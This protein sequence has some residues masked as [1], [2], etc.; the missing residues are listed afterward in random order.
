MK[1]NRNVDLENIAF[2]TMDKYGFNPVYPKQVIQEVNSIKGEITPA[3]VPGAKDLRKLMW[4]SIDNYDSM[5]LDQIEYCEEGDNGEIHVKVA[6]ADVD[7]FVSKNSEIDRYAA[8]NGT[9]V[10]TGVKTFPMLPD[11]LSGGISSLLPDDFHAAVVVEYTVFPDG[12]IKYGELYRALVANSAKLVYEEVGDWLEGKGPQ[13]KKFHEI[14]GLAKQIRLQDEAAKRLK[15]F[16]RRNGSLELETPEAEVIMDGKSVKA[17]VEQ[18]QNAARCLI[19]EFM[20]AA[21]KTT[22]AFLDRAGI[23]MIHRVVRSPKYWDKIVAKAGEYGDRL[24]PDPDGKALSKFLIKQKERDT[25]RF[26]DLSLTIVKL[27]GA[28]EY[29]AYRPGKE[30]V[31][32]FALAETDYTHGTAPNRRYADLIIQRLVKSVLDERKSPYRYRELDELAEWLS[33]RDQMAKKAERF[34]LKAAAGVLLKK[35]IGKTFDAMVTG[36]S[37]KGTYVRIFSP[38]VEGKVVRGGETLQVG[39][40]VKVRLISTKPEKGY[41][42]FEYQRG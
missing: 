20:V 29:V 10:Y 19:E 38:P 26:P 5:D 3:D 23:P 34:M 11:R 21:N 7:L 12:S 32:H 22:T 6:I 4:S 41:I 27:M 13:P 24:P 9:S 17:I 25:E 2:N 15:E 16:R 37:E 1:D 28:G 36:A 8:F 30:P 33:D 14:P 42:D 39:D 18:R 31:G 40:K 35:S